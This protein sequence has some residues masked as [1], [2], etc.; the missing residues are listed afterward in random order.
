MAVCEPARREPGQAAGPD[1][2]L[3]RDDV[4]WVI[5]HYAY[6]QSFQSWQNKRVKHVEAE[7]YKVRRSFEPQ[8]TE[9]E[10][11]R[12]LASCTR[13]PC[14][15]ANKRHQFTRLVEFRHEAEKD[16]GR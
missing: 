13:L 2:S 5:G 3:D 16:W 15:L 12:H 10:N 7:L 11:T 14:V 8:M 4:I 9:A 1:T 6:A